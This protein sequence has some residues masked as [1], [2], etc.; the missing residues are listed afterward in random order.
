[1]KRKVVG[2]I[3]VAMVCLLLL[4]GCGSAP[5][6][7]TKNEAPSGSGEKEAVPAKTVKWAVGTSSSG[8][9]PYQWGVGLANIVNKYQNV[10][11]ISAQA[12]AG[13]NEN[14]ALVAGKDIVLGL[15]T[16][17][18]IYTA[19]HQMDKFAGQE[20]FADLRFVFALAVE[21]GHQVVRADSDIYT[22]RDLQGRKFNI[23][24]PATATS[25]RNEAMLEAYGMSR[26]D[27]RIFELTTAETFNALRDNVIEG[28]ANGYSIGNAALV[29]LS[30]N[31]PVRLLEIGE[32]EFKKFNQ[33]QN[34]TMSYGVIPGG[35]Y[36]GQDT[37]V[38][39]WEGYSV[40]FTHKDTDEE[41]IYQITKAFWENL[42]ELKEINAGFAFLTPDKALGGAA[43]VPLHPGAE[44]YF[45]EK[46]LR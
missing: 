41:A 33:L 37:D 30:T 24:S 17:N 19:Y 44:K 29:D 36:K 34:N 26:D 20:Q 42:E 12:T 31:V 16:A 38:K 10:V 22:I 39:T 45:K 23:N 43:D 15:Q 28:T 40:L 5:D 3:C 1:M 7:G 8:S 6:P 2:F 11:E 21:H 27:F 4:A 46:G 25:T 18:D 32:E 35:T 14:T 13:Y 9:G